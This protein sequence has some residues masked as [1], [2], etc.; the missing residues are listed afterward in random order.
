MKLRAISLIIIALATLSF[1]YIKVN[2]TKP[3]E[4]PS[5]KV[6][7]VLVGGLVMNDEL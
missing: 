2:P 3:K 6:Q 4:G 5:K 7:A 1:T